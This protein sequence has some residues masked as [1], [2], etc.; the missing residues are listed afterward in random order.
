MVNVPLDVMI[1]I[2]FMYGCYIDPK[3]LHR[4]WSYFWSNSELRYRKGERDPDCP[5]N[6]Y[7]TDIQRRMP[8]AK[9]EIKFKNDTKKKTKT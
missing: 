5:P 2:S 4:G 7:R 3:E 8:K 6:T 1:D 9:S